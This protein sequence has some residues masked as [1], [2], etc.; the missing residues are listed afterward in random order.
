MAEVEMGRAQDLVEMTQKKI[1]ARFSFFFLS[2][3]F[4]RQG[5]VCDSPRLD[6]GGKVFLYQGQSDGRPYYRSDIEGRSLP[7]PTLPTSS[8]RRNKRSAFI[9]RVDGG[10]TTTTRRPW[11]YGAHGGG[12]GAWS[13]SSSSSRSW[14]SSTSTGSSSRGTVGGSRVSA[15]SIGSRLGPGLPPP[16]PSPEFLYW[17]PTSKA[18]L[19]SPNL[20]APESQ[21]TLSSQ[22][23]STNLCPADSAQSNLFKVW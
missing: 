19:V 10:G 5:C 17:S 11:N 7:S 8:S 18:W 13:S 20:G 12:S 15:S 2:P 23:S 1:L 9:G 21:A 22:P 6:V 3:P 4:L 16:P 14:S